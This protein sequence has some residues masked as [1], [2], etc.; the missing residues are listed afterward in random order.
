MIII[1]YCILSASVFRY[2]VSFSDIY[3]IMCLS[4]VRWPIKVFGFILQ[5][6]SYITVHFV[7]HLMWFLASLNSTALPMEMWVHRKTENTECGQKY[8]DSQH[9]IN[10]WLMN[11]QI[12]NI[13]AF[14]SVFPRSR[15]KKRK[16]TNGTIQHIL[17]CAHILSAKQCILSKQTRWVTLKFCW[18]QTS[19]CIKLMTK[20][21]V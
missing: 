8:V 3:Y 21:L 12:S 10:M 16:K 7:F 9:Y 20:L 11:I 15:L 4:K 13:C 17:T 5:R 14:L 19:K 1:Q 6:C 18:Y 2:N